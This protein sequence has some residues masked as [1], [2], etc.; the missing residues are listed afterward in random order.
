MRASVPASVP[1]GGTNFILPDLLSMLP[2]C[3]FAPTKYYLTARIGI[4]ENWHVG[5]SR[6]ME[7]A[8]VH[9]CDTLLEA[10]YE[11]LVWCIEEGHLDVKTL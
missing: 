7:W 11:L 8:T 5:Y 3:I 6:G 4:D 2:R 1:S 9:S 10:A